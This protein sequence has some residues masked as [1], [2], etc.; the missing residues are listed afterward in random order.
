MSLDEELVRLNPERGITLTIGVFDG[1]H[2]G[3]RHLV[4]ELKAQA[5]QQGTLSGII[6]FSQHPQ[7]VLMSQ[8]TTPCLTT[9]AAK[10]ALLKAEDVDEVIALSFTEELAGMDARQFISRLRDKLRM[11][12]LVIGPDFALGRNREGNVGALRA[13]GQ[14]MGIPVTAVPPLMMDGGVVSSTAIRG[15]LV[16]GDIERANQM[17]GRR[18]G[19]SG[20][21]VPGDQRGAML[22]IPT[23]NIEIVPEQALPLDGVYATLARVD[24]QEHHSMTNIGKNPTFGGHRRTVEV[25]ILDF[26]GDIYGRELAIEFIQR[27]RGER[28]FENVEELKKQ[29]AEDIKQGRAILAG[30]GER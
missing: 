18:F 10:L 4:A 7:S 16:A 21:V 19:L 20:R 6:T 13:L 9:L 3:H 15:A 24:G 8:T 11:R 28:Q 2:L 5:D 14:E 1:V 17:L 26:Q 12:G 23:A 30:R 27:L 22:G 29:I 25:Y